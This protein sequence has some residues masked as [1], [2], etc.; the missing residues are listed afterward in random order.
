MREW[1]APALAV[2]L[3]QVAIVA[4]PVARA[5]DLAP[6]VSGR[7]T[8]ADSG[9]HLY[10]EAHFC[11]ASGL[12]CRVEY[13]DPA[14]V[15]LAEKALDYSAGPNTPAVNLREPPDSEPLTLAAT[16]AQV[17]DAGFDHFVRSRWDA[18]AAGEVV[19]FGFQ[20]LGFDRAFTMRAEAVA[21]DCDAAWLCLRV[22]VNSWFLR[23]VAQPIELAYLRGSRQLV[24]YRG[25]TN[26]RSAELRAQ[27]V[28][29]RYTYAA[30]Q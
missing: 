23:L 30:A 16:D 11:S 13:T 3:V 28:E 12:R 4:S 8:H 26:L 22:Q 17:V 10:S 24:R 25:V 7:A 5:N 18:F 20:A 6:Y 14:G 29:I 21:A 2:F 9:E 15:L 27:P 19:T 1:R